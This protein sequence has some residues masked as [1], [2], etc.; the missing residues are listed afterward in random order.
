[1]DKLITNLD[2]NLGPVL[3]EQ[4][5]LNFQK[6]QNGVDGQVDSLNKQIETML[7]GVPLQDKNEVTQARIDDNNVVYST[8]KGRLDADQSTAETALKEERMTGIEVK[9]ARSNSSG[10]NYD[11]LKARLDDTEANLTNNM[12]AKIAQISS[13]PETFANL[14]AL[15]STYPNGKTGIFVTVDNGHKYIWANRSWIDSGIYQAA[16]LADKSVNF[17]K[18]DPSVY[19][20]YYRVNF[21]SVGDTKVINLVY[22][23]SKPTVSAPKTIE[24]GFSVVTQSNNVDYLRAQV[25]DSNGVNHALENVVVSGKAGTLTYL[26]STNDNFGDLTNSTI[27]TR[28]G[29]VN[30]NTAMSYLSSEPN[31]YLDGVKQEVQLVGLMNFNGIDATVDKSKTGLLS[32]P[33]QVDERLKNLKIASN[34]LDPHLVTK[35]DYLQHVEKATSVNNSAQLWLVGDISKIDLTEKK[36]THAMDVYSKSGN[37]KGLSSAIFVSNSVNDILAGDS[38]NLTYEP[39][40]NVYDGH[41][42]WRKVLANDGTFNNNKFIHVLLRANLND[43][44]TVT[45]I[46][47]KDVSLSIGGKAVTLSYNG[48]FGIGG[49]YPV[50]EVY[51]DYYDEDSFV[52]HGELKRFKKNTGKNIFFKVNVNQEFPQDGSST[53][54][55]DSELLAPVDCVLRLP[56]T[57]TETG[58]PTKLAMWAHGAGGRVTETSAGELEAAADHLLSV[59]YAL[60]D[61][62]GSNNDYPEHADHMSSPRTISAYKK[63]YDYVVQNYNIDPL[64]Y[65]HGH[66]MGGLLALNFANKFSGIVRCLA[67]AHP[68][69]DLKGQAWNH[70][71]F[72]TTRKQLAIEHNFND[73]TGATF[74][75]DKL[76]GYD[77]IN[78]M[79]LLSGDK[80]L[81]FNKLPI[82]IWHGTA[83]TT[84]DISGSINYING[85]KAAGGQAE[86][87]T[88]EGIAHIITAAMFEE[89]KLYFNRY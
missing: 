7:G 33:Q 19:A 75:A 39:E 5:D 28:V 29:V 6:I 56:S 11:N 65:V 57:Y 31:V 22:R 84:V 61:V 18:I 23:L 1:M 9:A 60:F 80:R 81:I 54:I 35:W 86:L 38:G 85:V 87:R 64:I 20:D 71:W 42:A 76:T 55:Q 36:I 52:T 26:K 49:D 37:F 14:S 66:S 47:F 58:E 88:V 77:P 59:G 3:R 43:I 21:K 10:K 89:I 50:Q 53:E 70:P 2:T 4:L 82:K 79:A 68:V 83:D 32:T 16:G 72:G 78:T 27:M 41:Q 12:N 30:Q 34:Q 67:L 25:N 40:Y 17:D 51:T 13:V 44:N 74:E 69:V 45:D 48:V 46:Y 63:A 24:V 15:K 62:N 8:L 73:K